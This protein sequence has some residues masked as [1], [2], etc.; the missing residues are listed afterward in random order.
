MG[1]LNKAKRTIEEILINPPKKILTNYY[2]VYT[3]LNLGI[4]RAALAETHQMTKQPTTVRHKNTKHELNKNDDYYDI[5]IIEARHK[6]S[7]K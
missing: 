6:C 4:G 3:G 2:E 7:A 5:L 1:W